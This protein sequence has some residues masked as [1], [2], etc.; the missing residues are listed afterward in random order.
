M[1]GELGKNFAAVQEHLKPAVRERLQLQRGNA[2]LEF[3]QDFL[4]QTDG[5]G[6]VLSLGAVFNFDLH[7]SAGMGN[8]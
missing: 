3:F 2:F 6:L 5:V 4:R 7:R 8:C 1:G